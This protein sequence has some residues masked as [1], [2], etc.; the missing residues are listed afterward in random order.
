MEDL[1]KKVIIPV[2]GSKNALKSLKYLDLVF[3]MDHNLDVD[4]VYITPSLTSAFGNEP[5]DKE[6][7]TSLSIAEKKIVNKGE[8]ILQDAKNT[9]VKMGFD[10]ERIKTV[11]RKKQ[12][13]ISQDICV[14]AE[15]TRVDAVLVTRRS[16]T[17]L[18]TFFMGRVTDRLVEQCKNAPVWI[19]GG[20]V[21]SKKV[22]ICVDRSGNALRAVDHVGFMLSGTDC[23]I[24][25]FNTMRDLKRMIP[26]EVV[27]EAPELE[28]LWEEKAAREVGETMKKA[29][30]MLIEA[31]IPE[32][33]ISKRVVQGSRSPGDDIIKEAKQKG[34]GT[35][36]MGRRGISGF[37]EFVFGSVT[38]KIL[39][40]A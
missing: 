26:K 33:Q 21:D 24:T 13:G 17:D 11:S 18:E 31:G 30:A 14:F 28:K 12:I 32:E 39:N 4:L 16:H 22:L 7:Y 27:E 40:Q 23:Q 37:K 3:K 15:S 25:L 8:R 5:M 19:V 1:T 36:V 38:K 2:D 6:T 20:S 29:K 34:Y 9:L 35:I 10:E